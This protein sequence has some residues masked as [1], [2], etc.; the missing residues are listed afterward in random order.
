[1]VGL[2]THSRTVIWSGT[3]KP[4]SISKKENTSSV[5]HL[6][7]FM[8]DTKPGLKQMIRLTLKSTEAHLHNQKTRLRQRQN[9]QK[10]SNFKQN[11]RESENNETN[12]C[13][14]FKNKPK[15]SQKITTVTN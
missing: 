6:D 11:S 9:K 15:M 5:I 13:Q 10:S 8:E 3:E 2:I 1:M 14:K 7:L 4:S 12:C